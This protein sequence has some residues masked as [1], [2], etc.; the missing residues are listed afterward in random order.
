MASLRKRTNGSY[1]LR[2]YEDGELQ[3]KTFRV[4][5]H[6][7]ALQRKQQKEE[8]LKRKK[9][10]SLHINELWKMYKQARPRR[11]NE[12][13]EEAYI[14]RFNEYFN[15]CFL[16]EITKTSLND[17]KIWLSK[18]SNK[19]YKHKKVY[20]STTYICNILR[21]V[22]AVWN[23]GIDEGYISAE[24]NI[25]HKLDMPI[26]SKREF[27]LSIR[28]F[29]HLYYITKKENLLYAE[30]MKLLIQ[31]GWRRG[32]LAKL[33]WQDIYDQHIIL[34]KTKSHGK[35]QRFPY[36]SFVKETL[37]QI[38]RLQKKHSEYVWADEDG[39][40]LNKETITRI[41]SKY[42][43]KAGFPEG[44]A[45]TLR[46][47]FAT[48]VQANDRLTIYEANMLL[49]QSSIGMTERYTHL[50]PDQID[51]R[52]V[53]FLRK[54]EPTYQINNKEYKPN[55]FVPDFFQEI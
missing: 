8:E 14:K 13:H 29:E 21:N 20:L 10:S 32:E 6:K 3:S 4:D 42:M 34:R 12:K 48:N 47:S 26:R 22:K 18:Q 25:F 45:H 35:D 9:S 7:D 15:N 1:L 55:P 28:E 53:D 31:T 41:V 46:H 44:V 33:K 49:R 50:I 16:Y 11:N 39:K 17:Y 40:R 54:E 30:F 38:Y 2:W 51:E 36:F 24:D 52:K 43:K 19:N 5:S 27:V 23:Y 37:Q